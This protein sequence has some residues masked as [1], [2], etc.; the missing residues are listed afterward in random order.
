MIV[1][2]VK[3][4]LQGPTERIPPQRRTPRASKESQRL[5]KPKRN[6]A[7]EITCIKT[8][9]LEENVHIVRCEGVI[10]EDECLSPTLNEHILIKNSCRMCQEEG[11]KPCFT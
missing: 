6:F 1:T 7:L 3:A 4:M 9:M 8:E 2:C 11:S 5:S 10:P